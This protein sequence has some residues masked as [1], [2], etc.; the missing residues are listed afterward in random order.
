M[1]CSSARTPGRPAAKLRRSKKVFRPLSRRTESISAAWRPCQPI[2]SLQAY[3]PETVLSSQ[4]IAPAFGHHEG[5][6]ADARLRTAA[7]GR[8]AG[9]REELAAGVALKQSNIDCL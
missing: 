8:D 6:H 1:A 5:P 9:V 4:K 3:S 7:R 2:R